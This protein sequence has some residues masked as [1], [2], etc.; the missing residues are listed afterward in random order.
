[1]RASKGATEIKLNNFIST[2]GLGESAH[3]GVG[4][5]RFKILTNIRA[6]VAV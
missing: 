2:G 1:M 4:C 6:V 3:V 5:N